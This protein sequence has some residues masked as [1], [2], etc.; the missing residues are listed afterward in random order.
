MEITKKKLK[1]MFPSLAEEMSAGES[2]VGVNSVR[3]DTEAAEKAHARKLAQYSPDVIDF[4]RRCDTVTQA[5]EVIRFMEKRGE[6][7][8]EHAS[9]LRKQLRK[10]GVRSFGGKKENDYYLK[11]GHRLEHAPP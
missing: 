1:K 8:K 2:R 9:K 4:I 11:H 3:T 6:I 5:E 10:K 7:D